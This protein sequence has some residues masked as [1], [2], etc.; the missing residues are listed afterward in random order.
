[1]A[2]HSSSVKH[3]EHF[4]TEWRHVPL[5]TEIVRRASMR[6]DEPAFGEPRERDGVLV[7]SGEFFA[8][9]LREIV[10]VE[11][12]QDLFLE[13][14]DERSDSLRVFALLFELFGLRLRLAYALR[15]VVPKAVARRETIIAISR[16]RSIGTVSRASSWST[17]SQRF[18]AKHCAASGSVA[19]ISRMWLTSRSQEQIVSGA[20]AAIPRSVHRTRTMFFG[21]DG[22]RASIPILMSRSAVF[23]FRPVAMHGE[24]YGARRRSSRSS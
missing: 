20:D 6:D 7:R 18:R 8:S 9:L 15:D 10:Q 24:S 21:V 16:R 14:R 22:S 23:F 5:R 4:A 3:A 17:R 1:M 19:A 2:R 11:R 13:G 12:A